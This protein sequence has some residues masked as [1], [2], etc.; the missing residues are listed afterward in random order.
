MYKMFVVDHIG[1]VYKPNKPIF[2]KQIISIMA[3]LSMWS[4]GH[5]FFWFG[6]ACFVFQNIGLFLFLSVAWE[7]FELAVPNT[8]TTEPWNNKAMDILINSVG[9]GIGLWVRSI[10]LKNRTPEKEKEKAFIYETKL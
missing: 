4:L 1:S 8:F 3:V 7:V 6:T 5:L 2:A 10:Y 9:F